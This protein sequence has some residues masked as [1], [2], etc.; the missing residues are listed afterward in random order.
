MEFQVG[1]IMVGEVTGIQNYG[2]FIRFPNDETGLIHIS[3][4]SSFFV[5][6]VGDFVKLGQHVSVKIIDIVPNKNL[7]RLSLKQVAERRRQNIRKMN[8]SLTINRKKKVVISHVDFEPLKEKLP[9]WVEI[10]LNK[11]KEEN[12]D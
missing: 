2:A 11:I 12:H 10:E 5:R 8:G 6:D 1:D 9:E 7:Y 3:E 4:I